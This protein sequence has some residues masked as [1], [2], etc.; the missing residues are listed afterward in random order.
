MVRKGNRITSS[1]TPRKKKKKKRKLTFIGQLHNYYM[2][3]TVQ[4]AFTHHIL[5]NP[6][7]NTIMTLLFPFTNEETE[8]VGDLTKVT[9]LVN[10]KIQI[11]ILYN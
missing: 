9:Q 3:G 4:G 6:C 2:P 11:Q 10:A 5:L 1:T 7:D 8:R